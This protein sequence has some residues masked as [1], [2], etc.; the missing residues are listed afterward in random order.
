MAHAME[1]AA[2]HLQAAGFTIR[3]R[4]LVPPAP[5]LEMDT[6]MSVAAQSAGQP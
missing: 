3:D 4:K 2:P 6:A 5:E 1:V